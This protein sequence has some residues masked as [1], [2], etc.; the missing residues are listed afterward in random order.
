MQRMKSIKILI[1]TT[2]LLLLSVFLYFFFLN[3]II[4]EITSYDFIKSNIE[5]LSNYK[6]SNLFFI[7]V[8]FI[9]LGIF[10]ISVL[11]GFGSPLGLIAGFL[12]GSYLGTIILTITFTIGASFTYIVA[13]FFF[14]DFI[15]EKIKNNYQSLNEKIQKHQFFAVAILRF[16]GGIPI[17]IQ[18]LIPILFN[19]KLRYY[20]FGTFL[21]IFPQA[22]IVVSLGAGLEKQIK[23]NSEPPSFIDLLSS[24]EIYIPILC[25][26]ILFLLTLFLRNFFFKK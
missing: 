10:W 4:Q 23:K 3:F 7:S 26:I 20:F 22:W 24:P 9:L 13:N 11:Q 21:G 2:Y 5:Y 12:F 25:F 17:Q 14:K 15:K 1:G 18:N 8:G 6:Q 19:I 16:I